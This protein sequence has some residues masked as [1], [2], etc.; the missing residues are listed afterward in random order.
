M[1]TKLARGASLQSAL[2]QYTWM[3]VSPKASEA[4]FGI[5]RME[6]YMERWYKIPARHLPETN[7]Q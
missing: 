4:T 2:D 1:S 6:V 3:E 5:S 7:G